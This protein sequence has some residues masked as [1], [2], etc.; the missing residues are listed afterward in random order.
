[1]SD[2]S[3]DRIL[4]RLKSADR[5]VPPPPRDVKA[6]SNNALDSGVKINR[7]KTLMEAMRTEV[8]V[9][10]DEDWINTLTRILKTRGIREL[11]YAPET[12]L[13]A[14]LNGRWKDDSD[15]LPRLI[16]YDRD[17]EQLKSRLFDIDASITSTAGAVVDTGAIILWPDAKEPRTMS[18]VPPV[19]IAVLNGNKIYGSLSEVMHEQGWSMGMP[20]NALLISGPSKTADIE[21]TLAFGVHGPK[22]LVLIITDQN[23]AQQP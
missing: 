2:S 1:M 11:L 23:T 19:H 15:A 7:L 9:V 10:N 3:R 8:H 12:S 6:F 5:H 14:V 20:T 18:L 21:L 4:S 16:A 17:I 22:E 13:G